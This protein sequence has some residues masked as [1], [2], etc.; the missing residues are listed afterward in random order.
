MMLEFAK[1]YGGN[2]YSQFGEDLIIEECI[3]RIKP[4]AGWMG[5]GYAVEF[6]A[7]SWEFCSNTAYLAE[8]GWLVKMLDLNPQDSRIEK[9]EI[10]PG[11]VNE[12]V[13]APELLSIDCDGPDFHIWK[14][15]KGN[16][17]IVVIEINSSI[18]PTV[19]EIPGPRGASFKSMVELG[20][21]KDYFLVCHTANCVFVRNEYRDMFPEI[22]GDPIKDYQLYFNTSHL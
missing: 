19:D 9:A 17:A 21:S 20:L 16:P 13:G 18:P 2:V 12:K 15:Y 10:T 6:G 22:T 1:K 11:N 3:R 7:P 5:R 8:Q 14:A 4:M